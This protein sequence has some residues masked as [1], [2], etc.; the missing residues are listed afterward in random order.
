MECGGADHAFLD[1]ALP[2]G[3]CLVHACERAFSKPRV[4]IS[5]EHLAR[6][7]KHRHL[8]RPTQ[9]LPLGRSKVC[10]R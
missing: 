1:E 8:E 5:R 9:D 10:E 4:R 7:L 2:Q 3:T 6:T